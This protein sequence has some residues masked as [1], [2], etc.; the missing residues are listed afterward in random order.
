MKT[1]SSVLLALKKAANP[2]DARGASRYFKTEKGGYAENEKFIGVRMPVLR[3]MAKQARQLKLNE[4]QTVLHNDIHEARMLALLILVE[5]FSLAGDIEKK[6]LVEF[7]LAETFYINNWDLVDCSA[8]KIVGPYL[9]NRNRKILFRLAKSK[10]LWERRI[11]IISTFHFIR[12]SRENDVSTT[13]ELAEILLKD[14]EDLIHKATGWMLREA[15]LHNPAA[16]EH[17]LKK[18]CHTMPR[19]M[20]RYAIEK[21]PQEIRRAYLAGKI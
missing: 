7:Y 19:T 10:D 12:F 3:A 21:L 9:Q 11:A 20:L 5:Q 4:V 16:T 8:Y 6:K 14:T 18:Y 13:L 15:W 17:F 1:A 2:A